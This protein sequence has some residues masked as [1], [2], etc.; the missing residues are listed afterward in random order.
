MSYCNRTS[1]NDFIS[2]FYFLSYTP[3]SN[4]IDR[5]EL[6][7]TFAEHYNMLPFSWHIRESYDSF[8]NKILSLPLQQQWIPVSERLPENSNDILLKWTFWFVT[9]AIGRYHHKWENWFVLPNT[10]W[11]H[12]INTVTHWM[13]LP[14]PPNN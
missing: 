6:L 5:K 12:K 2:S 8:L 13:L 7:K 14:L 4:L 1:L 11:F 9:T 10:V 3:M